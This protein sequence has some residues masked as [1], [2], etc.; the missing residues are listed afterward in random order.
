[1]LNK[2]NVKLRGEKPMKYIGHAK[3]FIKEH[4]F[5]AQWTLSWYNMKQT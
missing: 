2:K 1:M 3:K 5:T 4:I